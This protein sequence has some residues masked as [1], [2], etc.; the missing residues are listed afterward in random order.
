MYSEYSLSEVTLTVPS[1][2]RR[3]YMYEQFTAIDPAFQSKIDLLKTI[4]PPYT[5]TAADIEAVK[6]I[7]GEWNNPA[8]NK[9]STITVSLDFYEPGIHKITLTEYFNDV[10]FRLVAP[11]TILIYSLHESAYYANT[12]EGFRIYYIDNVRNTL[13]TNNS[14]WNLGRKETT[15]QQITESSNLYKNNIWFLVMQFSFSCNATNDCSKYDFNKFCYS[16]KCISSDIPKLKQLFG[17][18][19]PTSTD[20]TYIKGILGEWFTPN[21]VQ[22]QGSITLLDIQY[23]FFETGIHKLVVKSSN[24]PITMGA[25]FRIIRSN[26]LLITFGDDL[27]IVLYDSSLGVI[28]TIGKG[29]NSEQSGE[30]EIT[31]LIRLGTTQAQIET[32]KTQYKTQLEN[33]K[34]RLPALP[35]PVSQVIPVT[36]PTPPVP[37]Q[38][39]IEPPRCT[40]DSSCTS[41]PTKPYCFLTS[42]NCVQCKLNS[43]CP[44]TKPY[45]IDGICSVNCNSNSS[46]PSSKPLCDKGVCKSQSDILNNIFPAYTPTDTDKTYIKGILGDWYPSNT[47]TNKTTIS[48]IQYDSYE[49]GIHKISFDNI[50]AIPFR[51]ISNNTILVLLDGILLLLFDS[52][53]GVIITVEIKNTSTDIF[54]VTRSGVTPAA[55][56]ASKTQYIST[57]QTLKSKIGTGSTTST[58]STP[59]T[60]ANPALVA[61]ECNVQVN[62]QWYY[63]DVFSTIG[64]MFGIAANYIAAVVFGILAIIFGIILG[65]SDMSQGWSAGNII[66]L[67]FLLIFASAC[68]FNIVMIYIR[69]KRLTSVT[70]S[71]ESRPCTHTD[72]AGKKTVY[73]PV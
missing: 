52:S 58:P 50:K 43:H 67:I 38:A 11:N 53:R 23:D 48:D 2:T 27:S 60:T 66:T 26:T 62:D 4:L 72:A 10:P 19:T 57:L 68:I 44:T 35:N 8:A 51:I 16:G 9:L 47:P 17:S 39:P 64:D 18:Y 73:N 13:I 29:K 69:K 37:P 22:D 7:N 40:S 30:Y 71:P 14:E 3:N 70:T 21:N 12:P 49:S 65:V 28:H 15:T 55:I 33:L 36:E 24:A 56:E 34:N 54:V 20:K 59:A 31:Q 45:C 6:S 1:H 46:C 61:R 32:S 5:A 42:G 25:A 41:D 63:S